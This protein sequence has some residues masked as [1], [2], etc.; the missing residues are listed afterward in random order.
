MRDGSLIGFGHRAG[1]G[2][3]S[4]AFCCVDHVARFVDQARRKLARDNPRIG[5]RSVAEIV[6]IPLHSPLHPVWKPVE[7]KY[8]ELGELVRDLDR[9]SRAKDPE[10]WLQATMHM[11]TND[12]FNSSYAITDVQYPF[13]AEAIR[14][15]GGQLVRIDRPDW[16][17]SDDPSESALDDWDDWDYVFVNDAYIEDLEEA[18]MR[19]LGSRLGAAEGYPAPD[20]SDIKNEGP[21]LASRFS[22]IRPD[23]KRPVP[24]TGLVVQVSCGGCQ[25]SYLEEIEVDDFGEG[26][27]CRVD[28]CQECGED[29]YISPG[30]YE[31]DGKIEVVIEK[32]S[33]IYAIESVTPIPR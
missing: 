13:E 16:P 3:D 4:A 18:T 15:V 12:Y 27:S 23:G 14:K 29:F 32:W 33:G 17:V 10:V 31:H 28:Y 8:P 9:E 7:T 11:V 2:K 20:R 5:T 24:W 25:A 30:V 21:I 22:R 26:D 1:V 6:R 19:T